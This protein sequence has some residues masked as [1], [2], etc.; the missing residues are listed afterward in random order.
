MI[1]KEKR[2][3]LVLVI[4][5]LII[6]SFPIIWYISL[7]LNV[8]FFIFGSDIL[9]LGLGVL[10][11]LVIFVGIYSLLS[12]PRMKG[13]YLLIIGSFLTSVGLYFTR[14]LLLNI[15]FLISKSY[16]IYWTI[17]LTIIGILIILYGII[18]IRMKINHNL[19]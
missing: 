15:N 17:I 4:I 12:N 7:L 5:G 1:E 8:R 6:L 3:R 10:G 18:K 19:V 16:S 2:M 11:L 14:Y 13:L 9:M